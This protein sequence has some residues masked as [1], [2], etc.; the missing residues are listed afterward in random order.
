[1]LSDEVFVNAYSADKVKAFDQNRAFAGL[2]YNLSDEIQV[3]FGYQNVFLFTTKGKELVHA[4]RL[5]INHTIDWRKK[6]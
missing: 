4:L 2:C 6:K 1:M 3:L 5:G